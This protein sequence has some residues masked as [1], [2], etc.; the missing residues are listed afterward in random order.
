MR[1]EPD[2]HTGKQA[3]HH[4]VKLRQALGSSSK[5]VSSLLPPLETR[6]NPSRGG[7]AL[8]TR[9]GKEGGSADGRVGAQ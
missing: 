3:S 8:G 9:Q 5:A 6:V 4:L 7:F 1:V 2:T